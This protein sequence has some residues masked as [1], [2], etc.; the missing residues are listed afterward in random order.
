MLNAR[1]NCSAVENRSAGVFAN[2]FAI[3]CSTAGGVAGR[4]SVKDGISAIE[5]RARIACGVGPP[6]GGSP[7][8]ISYSTHAKL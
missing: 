3:A 4:I 7:P 8:I 2:A 6:N 5:C 1:R